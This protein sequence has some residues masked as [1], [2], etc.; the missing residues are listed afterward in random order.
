M[1]T[2]FQMTLS[3]EAT[4]VFFGPYRALLRALIVRDAKRAQAL[5]SRNGLELSELLASEVHVKNSVLLE[6]WTSIIELSEN[7]PCLALEASHLF[8]FPDLGERGWLLS[9]ARNFV[10]AI[11]VI[12]RFFSSHCFESGENDSALWCRWTPP[13]GTPSVLSH[14]LAGICLGSLLGQRIPP[15]MFSKAIL[16]RNCE[17]PE[18]FQVS[19]WSERFSSTYGLE[20]SFEGNSLEIHFNPEIIKYS[21]C[22]ADDAVFE[23]FKKRCARTDENSVDCTNQTGDSV[24]KNRI[25]NL[26]LSHIASTEFGAPEIAAE[27]G[28]SVRTLERTLARE[29][30]SLRQLKQQLQRETAE[31]MLRM[32]MRAK[33]VASQVGFADVA[34]FSRAF[35]KWTGLTPSQVRKRRNSEK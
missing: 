10:Q 18:A 28:M 9:S 20:P 29:G 22:S 2:G 1:G 32:G 30:I 31:E 21:F 6:L 25:R 35:N 3:A 8:Q 24:Y 4:V 27:L 33:E 5:V 16:P 26:L 7:E 34:S 11:S 15:E 17:P 12:H 19:R 23:F 14:Y 13:A